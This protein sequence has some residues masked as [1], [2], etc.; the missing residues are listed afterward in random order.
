M[1]VYIPADLQRKVRT[2]F[3]NRCA[4]CQTP[5]D[6]SVAIFE[7]EHIT[8]RSTGGKTEF[9]NL[10]LSCP[11]WNG[12]AWCLRLLEVSIL[13]VMATRACAM[14]CRARFS[15][16]SGCGPVLETHNLGT[17]SAVS[18]RIYRSAEIRLRLPACN[19]SKGPNLTGM[20]PAGTSMQP[21][22]LFNPRRHQWHSHFRWDGPVLVGKTAI[23]RTTVHV[24]G[25]NSA[26]RVEV[27]RLLIA[28]RLFPP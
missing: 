1:T 16:L 3:S 18:D 27:R 19:R 17:T 11:T 10:C 14:W 7:F 8:P 26:D 15:L 23:G 24:L 21:I 20:D 5:E 25:I 6:L 22:P 4:Y 12:Q 28:A 9:E 13:T 2:R